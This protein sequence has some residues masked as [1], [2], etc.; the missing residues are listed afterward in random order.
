MSIRTLKIKVPT[1]QY[2]LIVEGN[3]TLND[4]RIPAKP[5]DVLILQEYDPTTKRYTGEQ[6]KRVVKTTMV[7]VSG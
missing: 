7:M 3:N 6:I 5:G 4:L 1:T 2:Q